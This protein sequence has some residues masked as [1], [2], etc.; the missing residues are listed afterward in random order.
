LAG[1]PDEPDPLFDTDPGFS[2]VEEVQLSDPDYLQETSPQDSDLYNPSDEIVDIFA[3]MSDEDDQTA[4]ENDPPSNQLSRESAAT[5]LQSSQNS[6]DHFITKGQETA[7]TNGFKKLA[8]LGRVLEDFGDFRKPLPMTKGASV[9]AL[10]GLHNIMDTRLK[11]PVF[12]YFNDSLDPPTTDGLI[13]ALQEL[14]GIV[15]DLDVTISALTGGYN[16][17]ENDICFSLKYEAIRTGEVG[18][19]TELKADDLGLAFDDEVRL[20]FVADLRLDFTFGV[21]SDTQ[22]FIAVDQFEAGVAID[23]ADLNIGVTLDT[24]NGDTPDVSLNAENGTVNLDAQIIVEMDE[25]LTAGDGRITLAELQGITTETI[26]D[27]I[28]L[29]S[30]GRL[31]AQL[32]LDGNPGSDLTDPGISTLYI[33]SSD[34]FNGTLPDVSISVDITSLKAPI[35]DL[36]QKLG[37]LGADIIDSEAFNA[38]FPVIDASINQLLSENPEFGLGNFFDFY[39]PALEYFTLLEAFNFDVNDHLSDIGTLPEIDIPNFDLAIETHKAKLKNLIE[40]ECNCSLDPDWDISL[41]LSEIWSLLNPD[42]QINDYLPNFQLLLGL[43]YVPNMDR[44]RSDIKAFFG[45]FPTTD[46]LL[47][48]IC[49]TSLKDFPADFAGEF[50]QN[51]FSLSGGYYPGATEVGFDFQFDA[52]KETDLAVNLQDLFPD[53]LND[54]GVSMDSDIAFTVTL[55]LKLDFSVGID[56]SR[57]TSLS[58][59]VLFLRV[60]EASVTVRVNEDIDSPG[61]TSDDCSDPSPGIPEGRFDFDARAELVFH[62]LDPPDSSELTLSD[63]L[64]APD[65]SSLVDIQTSGTLFAELPVAASLSEEPIPD[66]PQSI[67]YIHVTSDNLFDPASLDVSTSLLLSPEDPS[68]SIG[69]GDGTAGD[70]R[71]DQK[72]LD[73][74]D[75]FD[76]ITIGHPEGSHVVEIGDSNNPVTFSDP[77]VISTTNQGGEVHIR[78][79]VIGSGN[80]SFTILG[81]GHTTHIGDGTG[82]YPNTIVSIDGDITINDSIVLHGDV[83]LVSANGNITIGTNDGTIK[84]N[85]GVNDNLTLDAPNGT[86]TIIG[87]V[88]GGDGL[89]NITIENATDVIFQNTGAFT[90]DAAI[91]TTGV[92]G[93]QGTPGGEVLLHS[94]GAGDIVLGAAITASGGKSTGDGNKGGAGG[95]VT[96]LNES[97]LITVHNITSS[98]GDSDSGPLGS[99]GT[100]QL[101]ATT[102]ITQQ[103]DTK[104]EAGKLKLESTGGNVTLN[105]NAGNELDILA[106]SIGGGN[107]FVYTDADNLVI[108]EVLAEG[109]GMAGIMAYGGDGNI[110]VKTVNGT[111]TVDDPVQ[112][113]GAG[114]ILLEAQGQ[115]RDIV[116]NAA[117]KSDTGNVTVTATGFVTQS[118]TGSVTTSD[119][120]QVTITSD[121]QLPPGLS[122]YLLGQSDWIEQG[123]EQTS[124]CA[125]MGMDPQGNPN[126]AAIQWIVVHPDAYKT[127]TGPNANVVYVGT[128]N[129]GLWKTDDITATQKVEPYSPSK[130]KAPDVSGVTLVEAVGGSLTQQKMYRYKIVFVDATGTESN[131]SEPKEITLSGVNNQVELQGIPLGPRTTSTSSRR[132]YRTTGLDPANPGNPTYCL[133]DTINNNTTQNHTDTKADGVLGNEREIEVPHP[134]WIPLTDQYP[135]LAVGALAFDPDDAEIIYVGTGSASASNKGGPSIGLLKTIDGGNSFSIKGENKFKDLKVRDVITHNYEATG[136]FA[137]YDAN[138]KRLTLFFEPGATSAEDLVGSVNDLANIPL[139]AALYQSTNDGTGTFTA[140][141]FKDVTSGGTNTTQATGAIFPK[142]G[143]NAITFTAANNGVNYNGLRV[144]FVNDVDEGNESVSYDAGTKTLTIHVKAGVSNADT[145]IAKVNTEGTFTAAWATNDGTGTYDAG[146]FRGITSGGAAGTNASVIVY[147]AGLNNA[148]VFTA[149][150]QGPVF[151]DI[152]VVFTSAVKQVLVA[153]NQVDNRGGLYISKDG[154]DFWERVSGTGNLAHGTVTDLIIVPDNNAKT[155]FA[156]VVGP[157]P[158]VE[159]SEAY[160]D[161]NTISIKETSSMQ[162]LAVK[163]GSTNKDH[164]K[165]LGNNKRFSIT[166]GGDKK[167][168]NPDFTGVSSM[169][170]VRG[171]IQSAVDTAFG[172]GVVEVKFNDVFF[173]FWNK[174]DRFKRVERLEDP[175]AGAGNSLL[176]P[177]NPGI[178]KSTDNG[179]TWTQKTTGQ[180]Q[181]YFRAAGRVQLAVHEGVPTTIHA[182]TLDGIKGYD[183]GGQ[184]KGIFRS[185][186]MGETWRYVM[187]TPVSRD[188]NAQT[189]NDAVARV[190]VD[191]KWNAFD[192]TG[193][194]ALGNN[195]EFN[196]TIG[197]KK[198]TIT[199]DFRNVNNKTDVASAIQAALNHWFPFSISLDTTTEPTNDGSGIVV[200]HQFPHVTSSGSDTVYAAGSINPAGTNNDLKIKARRAGVDLNGITVE[201]QIVVGSNNEVVE[202]DPLTNTLFIKIVATSNANRIIKLAEAAAER[203]DR[204]GPNATTVTWDEDHTPFIPILN[205]AQLMIVSNTLLKIE[206]EVTPPPIKVSSI[207]DTNLPVRFDWMQMLNNPPRIKSY[208]DGAEAIVKLGGN[209]ADI[210]DPTK[211]KLLGNNK[212]FRVNIN[213]KAFFINPHFSSVTSMDDVATAIQTALNDPNKFGANTTTV[214]WNN[215]KEEFRI[216]VDKIKEISGRG[217]PNSLFGNTFSPHFESVEILEVFELLKETVPKTSILVSHTDHT[218]WANLGATRSFSITVDGVTKNVTP[219]FTGVTSMDDVATKLQTAIN[220]QYVGNPVRVVYN[221]VFKRLIFESTTNNANSGV[222]NIGEPALHSNAHA[223]LVQ[224]DRAYFVDSTV[225]G[226]TTNTVTVLAGSDDP[227]VWKALATTRYFKIERSGFFSTSKTVNPDFSNVTNMNGVA[228][229]IQN[230]LNQKY[231]NR[232]MA[233]TYDEATQRFE[234]KSNNPD[235]RITV[236]EDAASGKKS[237]FGDYDTYLISA[238]VL[239]PEEYTNIHPGE[240]GGMHFSFAADPA[241]PDF[242]YV[243]G[244]RQAKLYKPAQLKHS[245]AKIAFWGGKIF[246][247]NTAVEAIPSAQD[248]IVGSGA[249]IPAGGGNTGL[250]NP[251]P[252]L[253]ALHADSRFIA[254]LH[255]GT[256][257]QADDGGIFW[258][259]N[260]TDP[261]NNARYWQSINGNLS[262]TEFSSIAY[263]PLNDIIVGGAQ[264]VGNQAQVASGKGEWKYVSGGDGNVNLVGVDGTDI[265]R[266]SV[267]N[268]LHSICRT[269]YNQSN[270]QVAKKYIS[271]KDNQNKNVLNKKDAAFT[272]FTHMAGAVSPVDGKR[273]ALAFW[274]VYESI[275]KGDNFT[276]ITPGGKDND[277]GT[278]KA[279]AYG[280]RDHTGADKQKALYIAATKDSKVY[281]RHPDTDK[282]SSNTPISGEP[283]IDIVVDPANWKIAYALSSKNIA[284]TVDGGAHWKKITSDVVRNGS[285]PK[286]TDLHSLE[287]V[288]IPYDLK[289]TDCAGKSMKVSLAGSM[290]V[291]NVLHLINETALIAE[292]SV[293]ANIGPNNK[294]LILTNYAPLIEGE[295]KV[296]AI[297]GSNAA[298]DLGLVP[299]AN[300]TRPDANTILGADIHNANMDDNTLLADVNTGTG[301]QINTTTEDML[302]VGT[303]KGVYRTFNPVSGTDTASPQINTSEKASVVIEGTS[304]SKVT[305]KSKTKGSFFNGV[306]VKFVHDVN[307]IGNS[308]KLDWYPAI[309]TLEFK[310]N[311]GTTTDTKVKEVLNDHSVAKKLFEASTPTFSLSKPV[312]VQTAVL[313]GGVDQFLTWTGMGH[314]LPNAQVVDIDYSP[315]RTNSNHELRANALVLGTRGRGTWKISDFSLRDIQE[316]CDLIIIA[317]NG[318]SEKIT[319]AVNEQQPWL[320]DVFFN[321]ILRY[322]YP[323]DN[324]YR[325]VVE[326]EGGNDTLEVD[327]NLHLPGGIV[328]DGSTDITGNTT[329]KLVVIGEG[330]THRVQGE[331]RDNDSKSGHMVV[332]ET[333]GKTLSLHYRN[334]ETVEIKISPNKMKEF[335]AGLGALTNLSC[336]NDAFARQSIP[337]VGQSLSGVLVGNPPQTLQPIG[338]PVVPDDDV[339]QL[340]TDLANQGL[341]LADLEGN[342]SIIARFL[343][344]S[345]AGDFIS[346]IGEVIN[347]FNALRNTLDGLDDID[348]NVTYTEVDGV[349]TFDMAI[350][351]T[352]AGGGEIDVNAF[353]GKLALSGEVTYSFDVDLHLAFGIDD[354][355]FFIDTDA[356]VGPELHVSNLSLVGTVEAVG[357]LGFIEVSLTDGTVTI[358]P[359]VS[360]SVDFHDPDIDPISG[361]AP[362]RLRL[363]EFGLSSILDILTL[364]IAGN[365]DADDLVFSGVFGV[366]ALIPGI[367]APFTIV[368]AGLIFTWADISNPLGVV[369]TAQPDDPA[370]ELLV[371][372]LDLDFQQIFLDMLAQMD[373]LGD[374]IL[375]IS[376]LDTELPL[377]NT[378][379]NDMF[380]NESSP[381]VGDLLKLHGAVQDYFNVLEAN[382]RS[383][384]FSGLLDVIIN[385]TTSKMDGSALSATLTNDDGKPELRFNVDFNISPEYSFDLDLGPSLADLGVTTDVSATVNVAANFDLDLA[386]GL[387]LTQLIETGTL[388]NAVFFE[389]NNLSADVEINVNDID[390]SLDFGFLKAGMENGAAGATAGVAMYLNDPTPDDGRVTLSDLTST[391]FSSLFTITP[392]DPVIRIA[393]STIDIFVGSGAGTADETGVRVNGQDLGFVLYSDLDAPAGVSP[394]TYALTAQGSAELVGVDDVTLSGDLAVRMNTTG[395][396]INEM[397]DVGGAP[398]VA[399]IFTANQGNLERLQGGVT[400]DIADFV[401]VEATVCLEK[402]ATL[403][404]NDTD[405]DGQPDQVDTEIKVGATISE[406]FLGMNRG[407]DDAVGLNITGGKLGMVIF[408]SIDTTAASGTATPSTFAVKG[409]L[410]TIEPLGLAESGITLSASNLALEVNRT[411]QTLAGIIVDTGAVDDQTQ[412]PITVDMSFDVTADVTRA[413]GTV[414]LGVSGFFYAYGSVSFEKRLSMTM[415]LSDGNSIDVGLLTVGASSVDAFAGVNGPYWTDLDGDGEITG[416]DTNGN[417]VIDADE[418]EEL[419]DGAMGLFLGDVDFALALMKV[420]SPAPTDPPTQ[421]TDLRTWTALKASVRN[422]QFVGMGSLN[423]SVESL[424]VAINQGGGTNNGA[425]NT[426]VVDFGAAPLDVKTGPEADDF[427]TLGFSTKLLRVEGFITLTISEFVHVSGALAFEK[428]EELNS[429]TLSDGSQANL[430]FLKIGA[431]NVN[432]FV[433]TGGPYWQDNSGPDG[434]PDGI[435]DTFDTPLADGAKGIALSNLEFGLALLKPTE[436]SDTRSFYAL[437]ASGS[438]ALVGVEGVEFSANNLSVEVNG[439]SDSNVNVT[440]P[441]PV[442][443]FKASFPVGAD[444]PGLAVTTG[445]DPD[446]EGPETAPVVYLDFADRLLRA[447]GSATLQ[448]EGLLLNGTVSFEQTTRTNGSKIIKVTLSEMNLSLGDPAVFSIENASGLLIITDQGM[449]GE[450]SVTV[451]INIPSNDPTFSFSGDLLL[452]INTSNQPINEAFNVPG[453]ADPAILVLPAGPFV[454]L[455]GEAIT[456]TIAD[457]DITGNFQFEQITRSPTQKIVRIAAANV[458]VS[459]SGEG[460]LTNGQGG[461]IFDTTGLAGVLKGDVEF[462]TGFGLEGEGEPALRINT[463]GLVV[464]ETITL[465]TGDIRIKFVAGEENFFG[466]SLT[467]ATIRFGDILTLSGDYSFAALDTNNDGETDKTLIGAQNVELFLGKGPA[468][469]DSGDLNPDAIGVLVTNAS[470]GVVKLANDPANSDDDTF[471]LFAFGNASLLGLDGLTVSGTLR[472]LINNTGMAIHETITLPGDPPGTIPVIFS[473]AQKVE[474]FEAGV[475]AQGQ[476][477]ENSLITISAADVFT[478]SGMVCFTETPTGRVEVDVPDATVSINIPGQDGTQ[479]AFSIT[480]A[481][482][483]F[484]GGGQGFQLQDLRV[485]GFSIFGADATIQ[486]PASALRPPSGD[487][488]SPVNFEVVNASD[489]NTLGYIDVVFNDV[490]RV[491]LNEASITDDTPEFVLVGTAAAGVTIN[492]RAEKVLDAINDRTYRYSFLGEFQDATD[493]QVEVK[494]LPNSFSDTMGANNVV[495]SEQFTLYFSAPGDPAPS[496]SPTASLANPFNGAVVSKQSLNARRFID[497]TFIAPGGG[498]VTGINGDEIRLSGTGT[499]NLDLGQG[500]VLTGTPQRLIGNTYRYF[501]TATPNTNLAETFVNGEV[502]VEFVANKWAADSV[503]NVRST[504]RF[505]VDSTVQEG[506]TASNQLAMGPLSL[507]GPSISLAKVGFKGG[508]LTLTI[509]IGADAARLNFGGGTANQAQPSAQQNQ[510][511]ITVALQGVMGTFGVSVDVLGLIS[512][513]ANAFSVPGSFGL[514]ISSLE[515]TVPN[516][517]RVTGTGIKIQYDPNYDP[518][519]HN[520]EPQELVI[521]QTAAISFDRFG[522]TGSIQP[523]TDDNDTPNDS[524]DDIIIPGLVIRDNGFDLGQAMLCYDGGS[525]T[526]PGSSPLTQTTPGAA[527]KL[528]NILEFDDM[529]IGVANFSVT[530]GQGIDFD[531]E[532][533]IASGGA[534]FFPGRPVSAMISDRLTAE[535]TDIQP[536]LPDTEAL[537]VTLE[538]EDGKVKSLRFNT[539]TFQIQ[540]GSFLTLTGRDMM[541]NTG[542]SATEEVV[543]FAS[544]GA[545]VK[546]GSLLIAGEGR[547][548]AFLGDG[549]FVAKQGFGV[550]LS[551]GSADGGSF[552]WPSWLPIKINEIGIEWRDIQSDPGDFLLTLSASVTGLHGLDGLQFSGTIEGVKIDVGKL[553]DGEFPIVDI[554][555]I[556]VSVRGKMFGGEINATLIGGILKLDAGGRLIDTSDTFIPVEERV[557]FVGLEGG[558]NFSGIGVTIRLAISELGPL[559]VFLNASVPGG[560]LLEPNS[561]LSMNDFSAGVEFFKTLPSLDDPFALR[562]PS[563]AATTDIDPDTWLQSVKQ[564]VV[565]QYQLIKNNPGMN[566]FAAAFSSPMTITGSAKVFS[567][568]TSQAVFNGEVIIKFSTDGKFLIIGKLNF[569]DDN[570]SVSGRLYADL[571]KVTSGDVTIL[572]LADVPDQVEILTLYGKLKMGFRNAGG[573]EVTFDALLPKSTIATADLAGPRAGDS[574]GR[575]TLNQ[576]GYIDVVFAAP[577]GSTVDADSIIDV[578]TEL[579]I[580]DGAA[581]RL[582]TTQSPVA[583]SDNTFRYWTIGAG[584]ADVTINVESWSYTDN[585]GE[586]TFNAAETTVSKTAM[587]IPYID[588]NY[589]AAGG[590][591]VVEQT[592]IDAGISIL[593]IERRDEDGIVLETIAL[594][595]VAPTPLGA[596]NTFR[597]YLPQDTDL[598][599]GTYTVV[600]PADVWQDSEDNWNAAD[601]ESFE[602]ITPLATVAGPFNNTSIDVTVLNA[603]TNTHGKKYIDIAFDA[604][605][606]NDLDYGSIL[607]S[608]AEISLSVI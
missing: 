512:G 250:G 171:K 117:V 267:G 535:P 569:A 368:D 121:E 9:G 477:D 557:F 151:N 165:L 36:L 224:K 96:V 470:V 461:F 577:A 74:L 482:R 215:A 480:G 360:F 44:I 246:R 136:H 428:G 317:S 280:A 505:T 452:A 375:G 42:F 533:F 314:N 558:F 337:L 309:W 75:G 608:G 431:S 362:G 213:D 474:V 272:S 193:W 563:L 346:E 472:V 135:S 137:Q 116:V 184:L 590:A 536:N 95:V 341:S 308:A 460:V 442:I 469:L 204:F 471:A 152:E 39:T 566:G 18:L 168:I 493:N 252:V 11:T 118:V 2:S 549:T 307:I 197:G 397:I 304:G 507:N 419:N 107:N 313:S 32:P 38:T 66:R 349:V 110:T 283:I 522:L 456:L 573:E 607:D 311:A 233:V 192:N 331:V 544:V 161:V 258:L 19:D 578:A 164:W 521:V 257:L 514:D 485:S 540:L 529:R 294:Q 335:R 92:D 429:V 392:A 562:D 100:V 141:I 457:V 553:L 545:E 34:F 255:D 217:A 37:K 393:A 155:Y 414:R 358:D 305:I 196:V 458:S 102:T 229:A 592:I 227:A 112:A 245:A 513:D 441:P 511:G 530:F 115:G 403:S 24:S 401:F 207:F 432:A 348:D 390:L 203:E 279:L 463:T 242:V 87:N 238:S 388:G 417:G 326:G 225:M 343:K 576:R 386:F 176:G 21:D 159:G 599:A 146:S 293:T 179:A 453:E 312:N 324:I 55:G 532:I 209:Q 554:A 508:E 170:S 519:E 49:T 319:V 249:V 531:G 211:W 328:F 437:K 190:I 547:N 12:K 352:F 145:V 72:G 500:G 561:G 336:A 385:D 25:S 254:F 438:V 315:L 459:V 20:P 83:R 381:G 586:Q 212:E 167:T 325:I 329:S 394:W 297:A 180:W 234:I 486:T 134:T 104:I 111:L 154:G 236:L 418:S 422:P 269:K 380:T 31:S 427:I 488:K 353:S 363:H 91:T 119:P 596:G 571:S 277:I 555:S 129:G 188:L 147:R 402:Q 105:N 595:D 506:G 58:T 281:V 449:A 278:I 200:A 206:V 199:P 479:E 33:K 342:D 142:G 81:S 434:T 446:G 6:P 265:Y 339:G 498:Q 174:S 383:P 98:G 248:Q 570:L 69:I 128:V 149:K 114:V 455:S 367:A 366:A 181:P 71:L 77:L 89:H 581:F 410:A 288:K 369:V 299:P 56:V 559:C 13:D 321:S 94:T 516:V 162:Y 144:I 413:Q 466:F 67:I 113:L 230:A 476:P 247:V 494:F 46:G 411:R 370:A 208:Q 495:E 232:A 301:V 407:T 436:V 605:P 237:L 523:F 1:L 354:A 219:D 579:T 218:R 550:F 270:E 64:I 416:T 465:P 253:T 384:T 404:G 286:D 183:N 84:G 79:D 378:S 101:S 468:R 489:L 205:Y 491:G 372:F 588:V 464:D 439:S 43:P 282:Y 10:L 564:Q 602:I 287:L 359:G 303:G 483:F 177:T 399:V 543:S 585:S 499:V 421:P 239:Q 556:G 295:F 597:Y 275:N 131:A 355:G 587:L 443:N 241:D 537:R 338:L 173:S 123:P 78:G 243:G 276:D 109:T 451:D 8:N 323:V 47:D 364:E 345:P 7:I 187:D 90:L 244:D 150:N 351:R 408:K 273:F 322:S 492:G 606:G 379:I 26:N 126:S 580:A 271:I 509:C 542:A 158:G 593:S 560:V 4:V 220:N 584:T 574:I 256:L 501:V 260:P 60:R 57:M 444:P 73:L 487:L 30:T 518:A 127:P 169:N 202:Y 108:G 76:T 16:V 63:L 86:I 40:K 228:T 526:C 266:Y 405:G 568:Y 490:N 178:Y 259:K 467:N 62:G 65:L 423:M 35:L 189:L 582:D 546:V 166:V 139:T 435:I 61:I 406:A 124:G 320:V 106:A 103:A 93:D 17:E 191:G 478:L 59:D 80:A 296:E 285:L 600:F 292:V 567:I 382:D 160:L 201:I 409:S 502:V 327:A 70:F 430:N 221:P 473:F 462:D 484:I 400:L 591:E 88:V 235:K 120:G 289:I 318:A 27:S 214:I 163:P 50:S 153:T 3:G 231:G 41:Y 210:S 316:T 261:V 424:S 589:L 156:A 332:T 552:K 425:A 274:G 284:V 357:R 604:T 122:I 172:S 240:Q 68:E 548:F 333:G 371:N 54:L 133:L 264:D 447:S 598:V 503:D 539:D 226:L 426:T 450:F 97:G 28:H 148:L 415:T 29:V 344:N 594:D 517:V 52:E 306:T 182:A 262:I 527:I 298:L 302:V 365:P 528:G 23:E 85:N 525:G 497:V 520:G 475:N 5:D 15:D 290:T 373:S 223:S 330:Y 572:F 347:D 603:A 82:A 391:G 185:D 601:E 398:P 340:I 263:D 194:R 132:I 334:V 22:F 412:Q 395:R 454:R 448:V 300:V 140:T 433:G 251:T 125:S 356:F 361:E 515:V 538:F 310:I 541:I 51:A 496:P 440:D 551:I 291:G 377:I 445:P 130:A 45:S 420:K 583:I 186:D 374:Q 534:R 389:L 175:P 222:A 481:A 524:N 396:E 350:E 143:N 510:S 48:Y 157:A 504:Q 376:A 53:Q 14:S 138:H 268:N 216:I 565:T 195:R 198:L 575:R 387:D 99:K